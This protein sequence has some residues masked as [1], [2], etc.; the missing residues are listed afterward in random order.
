[1]LTTELEH[2]AVL[3]APLR[4]AEDL[5]HVVS[6]RLAVLPAPNRLVRF[7]DERVARD[8][9]DVQVPPVLAE[10]LLLDLAPVTDDADALEV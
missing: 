9:E 2:D 4:D 10:E 1:M 8:S 3:A 6:V 7:P 5:R